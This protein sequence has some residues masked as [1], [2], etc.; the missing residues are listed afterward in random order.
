MNKLRKLGLRISIATVVL[1]V[2]IWLASYFDASNSEQFQTLAI[3]LFVASVFFASPQMIITQQKDAPKGRLETYGDL[4]VSTFY[5][6]A[7]LYVLYNAIPYFKSGH[8]VTAFDVIGQS[9]LAV[10][11][12]WTLSIHCWNAISSLLNVFKTSE[13]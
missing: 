5:T 2:I 9:T 8:S 1:G 3:Y 11:F 12:V 6:V 7:L 13:S 4:A 10:S